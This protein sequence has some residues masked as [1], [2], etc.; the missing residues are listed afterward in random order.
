MSKFYTPYIE[1]KTGTLIIESYG[2]S[3]EYAQRLALN[4]LDG[5][6]SHGG[7]PEDW[8]KVKEAVR[9]VVSAWINA[10]ATKIEPL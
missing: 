2:V 1:G 5:I 10:D 6:E 8:D 4:V 9:V 3:A 7:N